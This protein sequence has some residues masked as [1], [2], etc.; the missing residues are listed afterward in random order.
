MTTSPFIFDVVASL[1][2]SSVKELSGEVVQVGDMFFFPHIIEPL[3]PEII[4]LL[5]YFLN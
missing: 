3:Q 1:V 4:V 2:N 5:P